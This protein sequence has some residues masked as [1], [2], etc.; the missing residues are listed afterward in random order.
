MYVLSNVL[1]LQIKQTIWSW[2]RGA[3]QNTLPPFLKNKIAQN[4]A[5][6]LQVSPCNVSSHAP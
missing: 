4:A 3:A 2:V 5:C 6:V 1:W